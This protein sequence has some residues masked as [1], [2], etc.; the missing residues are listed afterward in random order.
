M[1]PPVL[2]AG[3][4]NSGKTTLFNTLTGARARTGNYPGVTVE[5][6]AGKARLP[7]GKQIEIVDLPGTYSLSA[8]SAEEQVAVDAVLP[9]RGPSPS[10]VLVVVDASTLAR[11]LY[12][13]VSIL[14]TGVPCVVALNMMDEARAGG[15]TIDH[16]ALAKELG[17]PVV[18][19]VARTG[20]GMPALL[21]ALEKVIAPS[22]AI[23]ALPL[24]LDG[25]AE[26]H[27]RTIEAAVRESF[28]AEGRSDAW[29]RARAIWALLS[30]GDDELAAPA[31]LREAVER[32]AASDPGLDV[33]IIGTRYARIDEI[34]RGAVVT[35]PRT[36][37]T[38]TDRIDAWLTH[39]F[40]GSLTFALVMVALFQ[41]LFT[42]SEPLVSA[43][44]WLVAKAQDVSRAILP[45]GPVADLIAQGVIAGVGNVIVFV[46]QIALLS[47]FLVVLEDCGY[48]ARVAFVIDRVMRGV[49]LHGRAF[50]PLLSGFAC[51]VPAVLATRTIESRRDRLVTMLALPLM[52]CSARLPVYTLVIAVAFPGDRRVLGVLSVGAIALFGMYALSVVT[53]LSA[54]A[55]LRRTVLR[56]KTP[57]LLLE[58]PPYRMP[59]ARNV[60]LAIWQRTATFVTNAGTVILAITIVLWALLAFPRDGSIDERFD[61]QLAQVD[62][63]LS[64]EAHDQRVAEIEA[65]RAEEQLAVSIAG[66]LGRAFEPVIAPLGYD[67]KIGVGLI[68]S[69]A[70]REVLVST[71]GLVYGVGDSADETSTPLRDQLRQATRPDGSLV[72]TPLTGLSLMI[73]FVLAAQCMSTLAVVRRESGSWGWA[74]FMLVYMNVLA[75]GAALLVYQGGRLLGFA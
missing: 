13:A 57:A 47:L 12:L 14:E 26:L 44:E 29:V 16:A 4:P 8:R 28:P 5:R 17:A 39:P 56:G 51:A 55:V 23:V 22:H 30:I 34:V 11:H 61:E 1:I 9:S 71:L 52:S 70:A 3:N 15:V 37:K 65:H 53:T 66:R 67:W 24:Q 2:L 59:I 18:P 33:A 74:L 38:R 43:I 75:Y 10:A 64:V 63:A 42:W 6:R 72:F 41:A 69:F 54:A 27:V 58:L 48:L 60:L 46:P 7:S 50:V 49:G 62:G 25:P 21:A 19:I 35:A 32:V 36:Q 40:Y 31:K 45:D 73:F 68:A 20:E